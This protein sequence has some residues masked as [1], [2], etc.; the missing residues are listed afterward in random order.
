MR[1]YIDL[2]IS[3]S[4][5]E[6]A[7]I[8]T[9]YLSDLPFESFDSATSDTT[10]ETT[11][12]AYILREVWDECR[13][14]AISIAEEWGTVISTNLIE[15][16]NWNAQWESEG[17]ER[18]DIDSRMVIR[19][20]HHQ[21]PL[22]DEVIDIVVAP[23]MSFG[24]GHHQ[25]TQ[26][27]CRAIMRLTPHNSRVLDVGCGTGILSLAALKCGARCADAIDIDPWSV[28]STRDAARLNGEEERINPILGSVESIEGERYDMV[29]ANINRNIITQQMAQYAAAL[30]TGGVILFSGFLEEDV[31]IIR[32]EA[33]RYGITITGSQQCD[34][35]V[36]LEA[37]KG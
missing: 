17:F 10:A 6:S 37:I 32:G 7:E 11:L 14:E 5:E 34:G 28:E 9:A 30:N 21:P 13:N 16:E 12:H 24:S 8:L 22:S 20:P 3:T 1:Q 26:M 36:C 27:M 35:W 29:V 25:T 33:S 23:R 2:C 31:E 18:V 19:A 15:D 4:N